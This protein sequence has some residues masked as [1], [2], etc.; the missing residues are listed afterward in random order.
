MWYVN[1]MQVNGKCLF[2]DNCDDKHLMIVL[3]NNDLFDAHSR[4]SNC[5]AKDERTHRC[6]I[7]HGEPPGITIDEAGDTC[8]CGAGSI[9]S[10]NWH[11]FIRDGKFV[12]A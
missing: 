8:N 2:W 6:W 3:P 5:A 1:Y 11:G 12:A 7:I 9:V 10:G 4:A